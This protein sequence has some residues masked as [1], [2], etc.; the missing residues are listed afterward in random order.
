ML[1]QE[2]RIFRQLE[3]N[4]L[5]QVADRLGLSEEE[6]Q[7]LETSAKPSWKD[8]EAYVKISNPSLESGIA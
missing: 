3:S 6:L 4:A 7:A 1:E 2:F 5:R 8:L